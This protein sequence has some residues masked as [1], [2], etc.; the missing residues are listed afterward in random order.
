VHSCKKS[1]VVGM[2]RRLDHIL[3]AVASDLSRGGKV[4]V[5]PLFHR[6]ASKLD[7][8]TTPISRRVDQTQGAREAG[9]YFEKGIH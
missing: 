8:E 7:G 6:R 9:D 5:A 1:I 3:L 2:G 4:W